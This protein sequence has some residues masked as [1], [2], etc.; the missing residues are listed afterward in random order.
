MRDDG[1]INVQQIS[2]GKAR[3]WSSQIV[4]AYLND[5]ELSLE[6]IDQEDAPPTTVVILVHD[7]KA[8]SVKR[9]IDYSLSRRRV[10]QR[11]A[12]LSKTAGRL[13]LREVVCPKCQSAI[14]MEGPPTP[15]FF[16]RYCETITTEFDVDLQR[17]EIEYRICRR[18][19][20]YSRPRKF[21]VFY[22]YFLVYF[23]GIH[24]DFVHCCPAC[25]RRTAWSMLWGNLPFVVGVPV[26]LRQLSHCYFGSNR[27]GPM[28]GLHDANRYLKRGKFAESLQIYES[29]LDRHPLSAG[30]KYNIALGLIGSGDLRHAVASLELA[31]QDCSNYIP[32]QRLLVQTLYDLDKPQQAQEFAERFKFDLS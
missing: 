16:C 18:C 1:L 28:R 23:Y 13:E 12:E 26:A 25:F 19:E 2:L 31:L 30:V 9:L 29:I 8:T 22:F 27:T 5:S 14:L 7:K 21:T 15:Q 32:A 6:I 10:K 3:F 20:M 24:M 4:A 11:L 17:H